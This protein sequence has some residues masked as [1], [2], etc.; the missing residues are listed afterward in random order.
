M[1]RDIYAIVMAAGRGTRFGGELP[2]QF[3]DLAGMPVMVHA[4]NTLR[5]WNPDVKIVVA[6]NPDDAEIWSSITDRY[7]LGDI[8]VTSGG[9]T[10]W[11]SVRNALATLKPG[12]NDVVMVHDGARPLLTCDMLDRLMVGLTGHDGA[13]PVVAL[14]DSIRHITPGGSEAVDRSEFCA[15]QTPQAF[16][17][18]KLQKAYQNPYQE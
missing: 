10:R 3:V 14:T 7:D 17:A 16:P 4:I 13:I 18:L 15:V 5:H 11:E 12:S 8:A 2:K 9:A 6:L 1:E